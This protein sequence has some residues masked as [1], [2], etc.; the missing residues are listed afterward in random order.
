MR[1][2]G[3]YYCS[4]I[5]R[6]PPG[7]IR[8]SMDRMRESVF[9]ILGDLEG[10][11]FLDLFSGTGIIGIEAASRGA[12]PVV[13]VEKDPRKKATIL[14]NISFVESSIEL[15]VA[16]VEAFLRRDSRLFDCIF[17]DPP[18]AFSAKS[19]ILEQAC[20]GP[21]LR[22]GGL[23]LMHLHKAERLEPL[24]EGFRIVDRREYGQSIVLF[25]RA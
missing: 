1:I 19:E 13:L 15:S 2:T 21:H 9:S 11:S 12:D 6:C 7:E 22:P 5:I 3:G 14:K 10:T 18:F 16:S 23:A 25:I 24:P 20:Q 4:R 17:L 8:P